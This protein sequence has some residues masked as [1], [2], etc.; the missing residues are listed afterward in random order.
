MS[1]WR[2]Q[3][4]PTSRNQPEVPALVN[5]SLVN[6]VSAS[7]VF[8]SSAGELVDEDDVQHEDNHELEERYPKYPRKEAERYDLTLGKQRQHLKHREHHNADEN[9]ASVVSLFV[10]NLLLQ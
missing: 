5:L 2:I 6:V 4:Q 8:E 3:P 10:V 1:P 7:V 9:V